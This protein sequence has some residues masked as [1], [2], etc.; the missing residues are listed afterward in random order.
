MGWLDKL[1]EIIKVDIKG[2]LI[3]IHD[4]QLTNNSNNRLVKVEKTAVWDEQEKTL[5]VNLEKLDPQKKQQLKE[6]IHGYLDE[7][8]R[9]L[10]VK[11]A[12]LFEDLCRFTKDKANQQIL[13]FF[14]PTIPPQDLDALEAALYL[15]DAFEKRADPQ[16]VKKLKEDIR[17]SF[18]IRGNNIANLCTAGY[19]EQFL[20]LFKRAS[21][22]LK[23][24]LFFVALDQFTKNS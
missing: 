2:P 3:D 24:S 18:G 5:Y 1:K 15:R 11:T 19:F 17:T 20:M 4:I 21:S 8:T 6:A 12:F 14:A 9:L 10:E 13:N 7:G 16:I 23:A 22:Y